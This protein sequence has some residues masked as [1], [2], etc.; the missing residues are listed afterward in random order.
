MQNWIEL[1]WSDLR[2]PMVDF[3]NLKGWSEQKAYEILRRHGV[4]GAARDTPSKQVYILL[5]RLVDG[6]ERG[7]TESAGDGALAPLDA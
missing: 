4:D 5:R 6:T 3:G 7:T 1:A 2:G